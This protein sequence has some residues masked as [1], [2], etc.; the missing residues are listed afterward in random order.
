MQNNPPATTPYPPGRDG[1]AGREN[2]DLVS[3]TLARHGRAPFPSFPDWTR[4]RQVRGYLRK[5]LEKGFE[6]RLKRLS[7]ELDTALH[8]V[9]EE[10]NHALVTAKAHLRRER[11]EFFAGSYHEMVERF[12]VLTERF[13]AS[14]DNRLERLERY[15]SP[16]IREREEQRL[17]NAV[18][19]FLAT[20]DQLID[21]YRAI[22][23]EQV[24]HE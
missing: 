10:S 16:V 4:R 3:D 6:F 8:R 22:I 11:M 21:D 12:N 2:Q 20:L 23:S 14:L 9:R 19:T 5:E 13:L 24:D 17:N 7:L 18:T 15:K 1:Q